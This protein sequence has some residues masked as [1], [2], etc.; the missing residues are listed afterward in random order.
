MIIRHPLL[1]W[2]AWALLAT[3]LSGWAGTALPCIDANPGNRI[4][5]RVDLVFTGVT[6]GEVRRTNLVLLSFDPKSA[7]LKVD[8]SGEAKSLDMREWRQMRI[9]VDDEEDPFVQR[10]FPN[11]TELQS[12]DHLE[13]PM[14]TIKIE[15]GTVLFSGCQRLANSSRKAILF[16]GS[17]TFKVETGKVEIDGVYMQYVIPDDHEPSN[18][19]ARKG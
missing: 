1:P 15:Q 18:P 4:V 14:S 19:G 17:L 11:K 6:R 16:K 7:M 8:D 10:A 5:N 12:V 13:V 9:V 2:I 3:H